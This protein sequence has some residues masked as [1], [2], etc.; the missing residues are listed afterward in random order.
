MT[1]VLRVRTGASCS[2]FLF[3]SNPSSF[4]LRRFHSTFQTASA[5]V[6]RGKLSNSK[7]LWLA[8]RG[9]EEVALDHPVLLYDGMC[10]LCNWMV[11]FV[12]RRDGNDVFRFASLQGE[13]AGRI[14]ARHGIKAS[15][16]DTVYVAVERHDAA[17]DGHE[18]LLARSNAVL[19][20]LEQL[21]GIWA[22][23]ARLLRVVP[24]PVRDWA[25]DIVARHRYRVFG[26]YETCPV[27]EERDRER[28]LEL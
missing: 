9:Y 16:L 27:P 2:R 28:F 22:L 14:L 5:D 17:E 10:G 11:R 26:R 1:V 21:G 12:L 4:P 23:T 19:F 24:R 3:A 13:L 15:P 7:F 6:D 8:P 25:Y 20:L 18:L